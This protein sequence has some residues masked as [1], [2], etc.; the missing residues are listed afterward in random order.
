MESWSPNNHTSFYPLM[1]V[2]FSYTY[3]QLTTAVHKPS[4]L[5]ILAIKLLKKM[6][7]ECYYSHIYFH[8]F[9]CHISNKLC[10]QELHL[11]PLYTGIQ[12][13]IILLA[14]QK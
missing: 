12:N 10:H 13:I 6:D 3:I 9:Y 4:L 5:I 8:T 7:R 2:V 14:R 11:L 1:P